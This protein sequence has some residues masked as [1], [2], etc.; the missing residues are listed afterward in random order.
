MFEVVVN[1]LAIFSLGFILYILIRMLI[2]ESKPMPH[3]K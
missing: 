1:I 3:E 2:E